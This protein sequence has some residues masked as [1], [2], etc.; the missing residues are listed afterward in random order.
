MTHSTRGLARVLAL[1]LLASVA[2]QL[3]YHFVVAQAADGDL[4][5]R[6]T[7]VGEM[8][9]FSLC[10]VAA[11]PLVARSAIPL[12]AS[13]IVLASVLNA[14]QVGFGLAM[15]GPASE[16]GDAQVFR[17]VLEGAFFF[18]FQAKALLGLAAIGVGL[19]ALRG[20]PAGKIVGVLAIVSG[21]AAAIANL[22][23]MAQGMAE[24]TFAAGAS[25][26]AATAFL[27]LALL[28]MPGRTAQAE[29]AAA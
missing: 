27:A 6:V 8:A 13:A 4:L 21:L 2:T 15:F 20:T 3:F 28:A 14:V 5:R 17:A 29:H 24:W 26:T 23:G 19:A 11:L 12:A 1:A 25:G 10:T 9:I 22:L 7:W 16:A 18:Y